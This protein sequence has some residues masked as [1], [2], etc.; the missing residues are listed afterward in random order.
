MKHLRENNET[1]TSHFCFAAKIGISC[2]LSG[3]WFLFHAALPFIPIPT[4]S[5]LEAMKERTNEWADYAEK[6]R[7]K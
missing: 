5:N 4:Q 2:M 7:A 6:R 1:Y 3:V